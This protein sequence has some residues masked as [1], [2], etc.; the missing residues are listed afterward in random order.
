MLRPAD[1][2]ELEQLEQRWLA[3][4]LT[5]RTSD[6]LDLCSPDIVWL[7]PGQ[8]P[9]C[10]KEAVRAWLDTVRDQISDIQVNDV[11]IDGDGLA[12]YRIASFCTRYMP[13]GST[14]TVTVSGWHVWVLRCDA[15]GIWR[16][17][18]VAWSLVD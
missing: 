5:G 11:K 9:I 3:C 6:L 8:L 14:E 13:N 17:E 2:A 1:L 7:P 10:G 4:E 16:V 12:A 18:V 15:G